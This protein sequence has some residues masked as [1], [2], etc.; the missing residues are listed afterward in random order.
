MAGSKFG[1]LLVGVLIGAW[2]SSCM[3][4]DFYV[5]DR[6]GWSPN[7]SEPFN[8]WAERNRFQV[9]DKLVFNY[10]T[11]HDSVLLVSKEQYDT[12]NTTSSYLKLEGGHSTFAFSRSGPFYFIS[13]NSTRCKDNGEK[14]IIIVMAIRD[15]SKVSPPSSH[16]ILPPPSSSTLPSPAPQMAGESP[17]ISPS[18]IEH[19]ISAPPQHSS[20]HFSSNY[21]LG[22]FVSLLILGLSVGF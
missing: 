16:P 20:S 1:A 10:E 22:L 13:G 6:H 12:C 17:S 19:P 18:E 9:K 2:L 5:G 15:K 7:P 3:A 8:N 11:E 21:S 14:L 4:Y